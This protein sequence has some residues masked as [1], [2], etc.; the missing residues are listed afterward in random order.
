MD[1]A[2]FYKE[3]TDF[4]AYDQEQLDE[5]HNI[6]EDENVDDDP[7]FRYLPTDCGIQPNPRNNFGL[8]LDVINL[9]KNANNTDIEPTDQAALNRLI[10][11]CAAEAASDSD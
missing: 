6:M 8:P 11:N 3:F 1:F 10:E 2:P 9:F 7:E 4:L 5:L